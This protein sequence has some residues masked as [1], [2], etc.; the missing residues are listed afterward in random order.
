[1]MT[2][3]HSITTEGQGHLIDGPGVL[4]A[5]G[6]LLPIGGWL[7]DAHFGRYNVVY[8]GIWTMWI[9]AVLSTFSLFLSKIDIFFAEHVDT[10]VS[11]LSTIIMGAGFGIFQANIV[12]FGIDQLSEAS[13]MEITNFITW[14]T[15]TIILT[16]IATRFITDCTPHYI[17]ALVVMTCLS[18]A[19]CSSFLLKQYLVKEHLTQN[20][21][22]LIWNIVKYSVKNKHLQDRFFSLNKQGIL[23]CLNIA[24]TTYAGP[25]TNEQVEDVK[26]FIRVI[27]VIATC[28]IAC[29]GIP[30]IQYAQDQLL[31]HLY[32]VPSNSIVGCY[33]RLSISSITHTFALLIVL[34]Y[35]FIVRPLF[36]NYL[37]KVSITTKFLVAVSLFLLRILSLLGIE[38]ASYH[39]NSITNSTEVYCVVQS[40][41][42]YHINFYWIIVPEVFSGLSSYVLILAGIE[43]ICAQAPFSMKGLTF[44]I[45]YGLYGIAS[46]LQIVISVPFLFKQAE[47]I[48]APLTCGIW[49]FLMQG[50]IVLIGLVLVI[51]MVKTYQR[52]IRSNAIQDPDEWKQITSVN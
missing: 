45:S 16:G 21:L 31:H 14:F 23:S 29:G 50:V 41:T 26:T 48:R 13:S 6:L 46:L 4:I 35:Q 25:F 30:V 3:Y 43:F 32:K 1:M 34:A 39:L 36:Y 42:N 5:A 47:W 8:Y 49:Y 37:Q 27:A 19:L 38:S 33:K 40:A 44:G 12:Q 17:G 52:R 10:W 2:V 18:I 20:P 51:F 28:I 9:G 15:T 24:K 11:W 7:A 22:S